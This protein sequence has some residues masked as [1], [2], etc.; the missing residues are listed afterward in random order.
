MRH[1]LEQR[2]REAN[3]GARRAHEAFRISSEELARDLRARE[4]R[5]A[6]EQ[7]RALELASVRCPVC[8]RPLSGPCPVG[9][10]QGEWC[11]AVDAAFERATRRR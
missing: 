3:T 4:R 1:A 5:A 6:V 7:L 11:R 2:A 10:L 8:A 9:G